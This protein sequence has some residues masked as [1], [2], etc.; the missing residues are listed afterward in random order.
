M[1]CDYRLVGY[2]DLDVINPESGEAEHGKTDAEDVCLF[3]ASD[4]LLKFLQSGPDQNIRT[5]CRKPGWDLMGLACCAAT[6]DCLCRLQEICWARHYK[7]CGVTTLDNGTLYYAPE[8][9]RN[10]GIQVQQGKHASVCRCASLCGP[11]AVSD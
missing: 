1:C 2:E 9:C 6:A 8:G 4:M 5:P 7:P 10:H 11:P 3:Y